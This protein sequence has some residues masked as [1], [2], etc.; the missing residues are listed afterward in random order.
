MRRLVIRGSTLYITYL[1]RTGRSYS[2]H[3]RGG[4]CAE[5]GNTTTRA[6]RVP[7]R[8]TSNYKTRFPSPSS[9]AAHDSLSTRRLGIWE[10][11]MYCPSRE[12]TRVHGTVDTEERREC[13]R[14]EQYRGL[15][16]A[17]RGRHGR[18]GWHEGMAV[19]YY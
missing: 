13:A 14:R 7:W 15:G 8:L 9:S 4:R 18:G 19:C 11:S 17:C 5:E 16:C 2:A 3:T 6:Q 1:E 10:H 12:R